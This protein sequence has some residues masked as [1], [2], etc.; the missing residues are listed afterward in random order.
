MKVEPT[1]LLSIENRDHG[2]FLKEIL[3][4]T[5]ARVMSRWVARS[6]PC[7]LAPVLA[8]AR[9]V[10]LDVAGLER[11]GIEG[12]ASAAGSA[13][14]RAGPGAPRRRPSRGG[15]ASARRRRR[16][17]PRSVRSSRSGTR[18][19]A[20]SPAGSRRRTRRASRRPG[21]AAGLGQLGG[22]AQG[23][24]QEPGEPDALA[25]PLGFDAIHPVVPVAGAHQGQAVQCH[26]CWTSLSTNCRS[27]ARS[28]WALASSGVSWTSAMTSWSW[29]RKPCD[30]HDW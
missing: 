17:R 11:P 23:R 13:G 15:P 30:P 22:P 16:S 3:R 5:R 2:G 10:P 6:D 26:Q 20:P 25:A 7:V 28:R 27:E 4:M 8:D 24:Q 21:V 1:T 18:R 29:S 14:R 12:G 9:H 19:P